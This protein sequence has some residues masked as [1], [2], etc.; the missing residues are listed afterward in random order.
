MCCRARDGRCN[1]GPLA[2]ATKG[3]VYAQQYVETIV[4]H[5]GFCS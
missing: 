4:I 3:G 1:N 2:N 5:K